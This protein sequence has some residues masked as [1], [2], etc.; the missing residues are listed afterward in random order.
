MDNIISSHCRFRCKKL[1]SCV[2]RDDTWCYSSQRN[3]FYCMNL[4]KMVVGELG[5]SR[6]ID[7]Q[8][9][10]NKMYLYNICFKQQRHYS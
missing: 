4:L 7:K 8:N 1:I 2:L 5:C 6:F 10:R 3:S 9:K